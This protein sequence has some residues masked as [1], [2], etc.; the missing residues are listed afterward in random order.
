V[1]VSFGNAFFVLAATAAVIFV[2][3]PSGDPAPSA[4]DRMV[5]RRL[6]EAGDLLEIP[7]LNHVVIGDDQYHL[8]HAMLSSIETADA[9][10]NVNGAMTRN[11]PMIRTDLF[12]DGRLAALGAQIEAIN[13]W[14]QPNGE[15]R[16][17]VSARVG[18]QTFTPTATYSS[19]TERTYPDAIDSILEQI[20]GMVP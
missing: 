18:N 17:L 15:E 4:E 2:H 12:A 13:V 1:A 20:A 10:A 6:K 8:A 11:P 16:I 14:R 19:A 3:N 9:R 7:I 5:T